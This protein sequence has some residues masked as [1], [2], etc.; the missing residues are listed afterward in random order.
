MGQLEKTVILNSCENMRNNLLNI[1]RFSTTVKEHISPF[2][3]E[4]NIQDTIIELFLAKKLELSSPTFISHW[5]AR[6]DP[7]GRVTSKLET[8]DN[9]LYRKYEY[10][11]DSLELQIKW[12][13]MMKDLFGDK[14]FESS[15]PVDEETW[16]VREEFEM[17]Y[18]ASRLS[19]E[20]AVNETSPVMV[21]SLKA[22]ILIKDFTHEKRIGNLVCIEFGRLNT[23]VYP[24][25]FDPKKVFYC[26][27]ETLHEAVKRKL[28][29]TKLKRNY[30]L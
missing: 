20:W 11:V 10:R 25:E 26:E 13:L 22:E 28:C 16:D 14:I 12:E 3:K 21:N 29:T 23:S 18:R 7:F 15:Y 9:D 24:Q 19:Q 8:K 27:I 1:L 4:D 6:R 5:N 17:K 2:K 30:G